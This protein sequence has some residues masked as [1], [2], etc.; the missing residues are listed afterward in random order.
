MSILATAIALSMAGVLLWA[1]LEKLR[2]LNPVVSTIRGL[3]V[4][5]QLAARGAVFLAT[6]EIA[7]ALGLMFAP[8]A[9]WTLAGVTAL[10]AT[11]ASAGV[12]ALRHDA[13]IRCSCFG[14]GGQGRLGWA[15]IA[16]VGPWLAA[17][18][19]VRW[20]TPDPLPLPTGAGRFMVVALALSCLR[21]GTVATAWLAARDDRRSAEEMF[22]WLRSR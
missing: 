20:G 16:M 10:A 3:G 14:P 21:V 15:Q 13:P 7:V 22:A 6:A 8:H 1:G 11:F 2:D 9:T 17:A 19:V 12:L 18:A 5:H 4:P